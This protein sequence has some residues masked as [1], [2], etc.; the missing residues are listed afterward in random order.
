MMMMTIAMTGVGVIVIISIVILGRFG[1]IPLPVAIDLHSS[2]IIVIEIVI[3]RI[4]S[5]DG[6]IASRVESIF[7]HRRVKGRWFHQQGISGIQRREIIEIT[8]QFL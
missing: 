4:S 1:T 6:G 2:I 3:V 5:G 7:S 8:I